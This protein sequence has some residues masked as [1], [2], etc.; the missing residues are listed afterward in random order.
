MSLILD[1]SSAIQHSIDQAYS[2][3]LNSLKDLI[4]WL[5][6]PPNNGLYRDERDLPRALETYGRLHTWGEESR[7]AL[8]AGSR[9]SL[10]HTLRQDDK[11]RNN[12]MKILAKVQRQVLFGG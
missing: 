2:R 10:D 8:P 6:Y 1:S 7:A 3:C 12:F 5:T 9:E 11:L 4:V